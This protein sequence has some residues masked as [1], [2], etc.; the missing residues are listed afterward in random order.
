[1]VAE[2]TSTILSIS[3]KK[4]NDRVIEMERNMRRLEQYS[5]CECLK[6]AG[7]PNSIIP[8][9]RTSHFNFR[10][11][12]GGNEANGHSSMCH[13]LGETGRAI[14]KLLNRKD[15]QNVWKEKHKLTSV[16]LYDDNTDTNNKRK[17]FSNQS[18]CPYCRK[19]YSVVQDLN[20][21]GLID[22]FW[23]TNGT[24]KIRESSQSKPISITHESDLH[25][26]G[27]KKLDID[28]IDLGFAFN[29]MS[30]SDSRVN[31]NLYGVF[32]IFIVQGLFI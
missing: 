15:A 12:R 16:N 31:D 5:C 1:M 14:V 26:W 23:I 28:M 4:L 17:I 19:L 9:R 11:A 21:E 25:F 22:S 3:H 8:S 13:R 6:I 10:E 20:N 29:A 27:I 24:I 30:L 18:L 32:H 7:V 2:K